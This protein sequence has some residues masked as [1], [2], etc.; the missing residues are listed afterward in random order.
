MVEPDQ[1]AL[2]H[3][4]GGQVG[5]QP[6][7]AL[8]EDE[9]H[10]AVPALPRRDRVAAD[11]VHVHVD[12]EQIVA[13]LGPVLDHVVDEVATVQALALQPPLHVGER[14][15]HGVDL[16]GLD[17]DDELSMVRCRSLRSLG[18]SVIGFR[19][20]GASAHHQAAQQRGRVV[21]VLLHD[22]A[23]QVRLA[24]HDR[25]HQPRVLP[26]RVG[27]VGAQHRDRAAASRAGSPAPR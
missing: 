5:E 6:D 9:L 15:H 20:P 7:G 27:D 26:V 19:W 22:P 24:G 23:G 8:V 1:V 16:A 10:V 17:A 4:G 18:S 11:G 14:H 13:A 3:R 25:P 12:G 21:A 2:D